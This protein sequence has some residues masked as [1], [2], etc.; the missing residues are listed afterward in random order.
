[1]PKGFP[2]Q[3]YASKI[4]LG[5]KP[6]GDTRAHYSQEDINKWKEFFNDEIVNNLSCYCQGTSDSRYILNKK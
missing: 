6:D 4:L 2:T 5:L 3:I 1:V